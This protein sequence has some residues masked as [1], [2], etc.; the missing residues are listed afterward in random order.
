MP[1]FFAKKKKPVHRAIITFDVTGA[2]SFLFTQL[3]AEC[4]FENPHH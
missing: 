4:F 1:H 3:C 2:I